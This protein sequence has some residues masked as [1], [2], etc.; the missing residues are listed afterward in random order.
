[1]QPKFSLD[2]KVS[3]VMRQGRP[4]SSPHPLRRGDGP[5]FPSHLLDDYNDF[6]SL[7]GDRTSLPEQPTERYSWRITS[8]R[9]LPAHISLAE[10]LSGPLK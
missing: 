1:M 3:L 4:S 10:G 8:G 7:R 5:R 2:G 6:G 9:R